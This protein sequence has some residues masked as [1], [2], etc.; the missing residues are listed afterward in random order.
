MKTNYCYILLLAAAGILSTSCKKEAAP[1]I[2]D[3]LG[4]VQ[5]FTPPADA[6]PMVKELYGKYNVWVR[7]DFN[8]W[9]EVTNAILDTDP[10]NRYGVGKIEDADRESALIYSKKLLSGVSDK[11]AKTFF[12]L[13]FFFVKTYGAGYWASELKRIGRS[14][15]VICWPNHLKDALPITDPENHYYQDSVLAH[16]IWSNI[17]IMVGARMEAPILE[18]ALAGK[19]YDNRQALDKLD[20]E[21]DNDGDLEKWIAAKEELAKNGGFITASGSTTFESD[22]A[23][24][25]EL[26]ALESYSN[27]KTKYLDNSPARAKK[28]EIIIKYFKSYDWDIQAT[29][30]LYRQK[31]DE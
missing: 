28:Y 4:I 2:T 13:E 18:F 30:N 3:N 7:M 19:A 31:H 26:L 25:L 22:F 29:G 20:K 12:P 1:G 27:I 5:Q 23:E 6:A 21:L 16:Q 14:R 17:G 15:L 11:Y 8:N 24:W 10:F 9:K